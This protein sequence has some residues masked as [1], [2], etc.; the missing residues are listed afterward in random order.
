MTTETPAK[1]NLTLEVH[2]RRGDGYHELATWMVPLALADTLDVALAEDG[3]D[4]FETD[5]PG[6]AWHA[7]NLV[8]R[9]TALFREKTGL[10]RAYR[11]RLRK[12][13]PI[14]AGLAGGSSN[15]AGTLKLLNALHGTPFAEADL[16]ALAAELGSDVAFFVRGKSAWCTGRGEVMTPKPLPSAAW[17]VLAKPGFGVATAEAYAAY[18]QRP[19]DARRGEVAVSRWGELRND[20][21]R[22]VFPKYLLLPV[23]KAWF[24]R[25][26]E[27]G[28]ALM[29][30]SGSTVFGLTESEAT[31][32][33]LHRRF[34]EEHG[35]AFW[36][37]VY[38]VEG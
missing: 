11:V 32:E 19:A 5:A 17:C 14:G 24:A 3:A 26:P 36:T 12:R 10:G 18:A 22:A 37:G 2:G 21:E 28:L 35:Q 6:L 13:I 34:V 8:Y 4:H 29:S 23:L 33:G 9:A 30:G 20:L 16:E 27:C 31:A 7:P 25:Q 1:V 38:R 15:A